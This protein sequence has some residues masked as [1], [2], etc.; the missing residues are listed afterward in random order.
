VLNNLDTKMKLILILGSAMLFTGCATTS[1]NTEVVVAN[2]YVVR[3]AP[4]TMKTLPPLPPM[5]VNPDKASNA[6]IATFMNNTEGYAANLESMIQTLVNF[7]EKPVTTAEA[8]TLQPVTPLSPATPNASRVI[9]P[10]TT[11]ETAPTQ[12]RFSTALAKARAAI[13]GK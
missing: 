13:T 6:E 8:G 9:Q 2:Q 12:S 4:D 10:Q 5:L 11:A 3:T 1:P 7:Y